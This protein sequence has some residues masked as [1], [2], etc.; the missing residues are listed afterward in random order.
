MV[1]RLGD[2]DEAAFLDTES[3]PRDQQ[4]KTDVNVSDG[5]RMGWFDS[6]GIEDEGIANTKKRK[7]CGLR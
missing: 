2:A 6:E 3:V 7:R 5:E 4:G 1:E